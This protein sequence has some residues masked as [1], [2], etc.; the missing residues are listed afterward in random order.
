METKTLGSGAQALIVSAQGFGCMGI[1]A[2]YGKPIADEDAV[3][4]MK[5]A[6]DNGATHWDT[7]EAYHA[8]LEDGSIKWNEE[9]VG[10]AIAVVGR[11]KLTIAT[12]YQPMMHDNT[13]TA[14]QAVEACRA[15]N[16]RLGIDCCDLY[17]VHRLA[18]NTPVEEQAKAMNAVLEA[19]L[20]KHIGVSEFSPKTLRA[21]HAI[22]P[23]T[24][25]QQEW[26]LMN[27][28]LEDELVPCCRELGIGI[29][30][31]APLCRSLLS[32]SVKS[33]ADLGGGADDM[34][35]AR[36]GKLFA[37]NLEKNAQLIEA[38]VQIAKDFKVSAAQLSLAW[39][40]NQ[41][42]DV[43]PIPGTTKIPHLEENLASRSVV[44]SS[45]QMDLIAAAIPQ[46]QIAGDRYAGG[47]V[48]ATF[49][50]NL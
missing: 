7:A 46:D 27:R 49:K 26:S 13:L 19:G 6:A 10:K 11:E 50:E 20:A 38:V 3:A 17:Y 8:K 25:V 45:D 15:S 40:A 36:Y 28:D 4:V 14:E 34:R 29:V 48:A 18:K 37:G 42:S 41:G 32:G 33:S 5:H 23:V 31:Y 1:T 24:C 16:K 22:C 43:L 47:P 39:V 44:L 12:K 2:F 9:V 30:A 35:P 21:F